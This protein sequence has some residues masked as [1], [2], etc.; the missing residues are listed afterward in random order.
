[1]YALRDPSELANDG[2]TV[3]EA[4]LFL[5]SQFDGERTLATMAEAFEN[6]YG[7]PVADETLLE[8]VERLEQSRL[9]DSPTFDA[10]LKS[11]HDEYRQAPVRES[12]C[13]DLWTSADEARNYMAN[14]L[15]NTNG[16]VATDRVVGLI[17]P[18]LDFPRGFPCYREAYGVLT[19][20][21][22]PERVVIL[23]T[24]HFGQATSVVATTRAFQTPFGTTAVDESFLR[25]VEQRCGQNLCT[26]E[27][28]HK[29]EHSVELQVMCL[30]HLFGADRFKIVPFLCPNPC[31]PSGM[32][33]YDGNGVDLDAFANAIGD[34]LRAG[35]GDTLLVA[36]AD[37]SH[38]GGQF[39]DAFQI[40]EEFLS[41]V[42][43]RDR[44]ALE[45]LIDR[46]PTS[47]VESVAR[48]ENPTRICS[49]GCMYVVAEALSDAKPE[50][51]GYHQAFDD[52][53]QI[54]VTCSAI[55][56]TIPA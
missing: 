2:L 35:G 11:L 31:G 40:G 39:G 34:T 27:F 28:D 56:Y 37:L 30:Q 21:D 25:D 4:A 12:T 18:H 14:M 20:R 50:L 33:P 38:I 52:E 36:G 9:L 45:R 53:Q 8:L 26:H 3:S 46:E 41:T 51:L 49:A 10:F 32:K 22:C 44:K 43:S 17:A 54:C 15:P 6:R 42:E 5:L 23:G 48:D 47:F 1:M 55:A 19:G 24:N 7:Q 13:A 16:Q 29:R